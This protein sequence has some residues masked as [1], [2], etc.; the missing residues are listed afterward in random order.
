MDVDE[1][2]GHRLYTGLALDY[3]HRLWVPNSASHTVSAVAELLVDNP[4]IFCL[5][6]PTL[7]NNIWQCFA[8]LIVYADN[9]RLAIFMVVC[10]CGI[11]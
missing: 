9:L 7:Y 4:L 10:C 6:Y 11:M 5:F 8:Q 2:N 1:F 3:R